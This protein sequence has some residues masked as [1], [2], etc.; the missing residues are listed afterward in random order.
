MEERG[1]GS[2]ADRESE[3]SA[4]AAER[5]M[6]VQARFEALY[7]D[8]AARLAKQRRIQEEK[9]QKEEAERAKRASVQKFD[10]ERFEMRQRRIESILRER[11]QGREVVRRQAQALKEVE[12]MAECTFKPKLVA[13][14]MVQ[15]RGSAEVRNR[16]I[17]VREAWRR[18][19]SSGTRES[20]KWKLESRSIDCS[21]ASARELLC[22]GGQSQRVILCIYCS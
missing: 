7:A 10:P 21:S 14:S 17:A 5:A 22:Q 3:G 1:A 16:K 18:E 11:A 12:E 6:E 20:K 13:K 9:R 19:N 15:R 4:A 8:S 2:P